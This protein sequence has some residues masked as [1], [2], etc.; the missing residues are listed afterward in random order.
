MRVQ[1]RYGWWLALAVLLT[2]CAPALYA[3]GGDP[4][5]ALAE[6]LGAPDLPEQV[7][8]TAPALDLDRLE[9]AV[10]D[11][12]N[13]VRRARGLAPLT[14]N[15]ALAHTAR[16]YS[17]DMAG[18]QVFGHHGPDGSTPTDRAARDGLRTGG[19]RYEGVGE[20]V[21]LAHRFREYRV[22][23]AP[24]GAAR[25]E[26]DWRCEEEIAR[27][28]VDTW[29]ESPTHRANLLSPI[30]EAQAIGAAL[31]EGATVFIT[32]NLMPHRHAAR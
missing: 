6:L 25:Y 9:Q 10:S 26:A 18:E 17:T 16:A 27:H 30:Y 24:G 21:Y 29:L 20:N 5:A 8:E 22:Y 31:G 1:L 28:A 23:H 11:A 13:E 19:G 12:V 4:E 7:V 3:P 32:Q 15:A 2:G 14:W